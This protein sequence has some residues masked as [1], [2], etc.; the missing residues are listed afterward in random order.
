MPAI[1]P[2]DRPPEPLLD[3]EEGEGPRAAAGGALAVPVPVTLEGGLMAVLAGN[4]GT[5]TLGGL[6]ATW[7]GPCVVVGV[8]VGL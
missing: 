8:V 5:A 7:V 3:E 4:I 2:V 6:S 1:A